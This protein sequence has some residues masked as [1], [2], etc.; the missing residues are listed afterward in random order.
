MGARFLRSLNP[1]ATATQVFEGIG[2][3]GSL[4]GMD[5]GDRH[6]FEQKDRAGNLMLRAVTEYG[7]TKSPSRTV[8]EAAG[9]T[10]L[11][12]LI[13]SPD[14]GLLFELPGGERVSSLRK[15][16]GELIGGAA[17]HVLDGTGAV[18]AAVIEGTPRTTSITAAGILDYM[19]VYANTPTL[20]SFGV[21]GSRST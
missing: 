7:S 9:G 18:L 6:A 8:V 4:V 3:L 1:V 5:E 19:D 20:P 11:G 15:A 21:K 10:P 13:A 14:S 2:W 12:S 17:F 16:E